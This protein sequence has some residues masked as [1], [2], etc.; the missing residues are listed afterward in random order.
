[1]VY[2]LR[3]LQDLQGP[4]IRVDQV[5]N[6]GV[7]IIEEDENLKNRYDEEITYENTPIESD[8]KDEM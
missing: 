6:G 2:K 5:E 4:K 1:M 3:V 8:T 7:E